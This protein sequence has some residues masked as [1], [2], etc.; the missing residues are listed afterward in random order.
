MAA[1]IL[2][3]VLSGMTLVL[4]TLTAVLVAT[5]GGEVFDQFREQEPDLVQSSG[6]TE[7]QF[8][9]TFLVVA[10]GLVLWSAAALVLAV[11]AF[12]G[13]GWARITLAVSGVC[14]A[15]LTLVM[16]ISGPPLLVPAIA[17]GVGTWL[18]LR[19]EVAAWF[20]TVR[21]R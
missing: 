18:L 3:W 16:A 7:Q 15:L 5:Q 14:A 9:A 13:R 2:T 21:R 11:L 1:C 8:V 19:P 12:V 4:T 20:A 17:L 6:M 10:I